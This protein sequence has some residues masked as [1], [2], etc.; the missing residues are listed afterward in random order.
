MTT[1]SAGAL[2]ASLCRF[3][4]C[5]AS[6]CSCSVTSL[7]CCSTGC[8]RRK[9]AYLMMPGCV[10]QSCQHT[11]VH[12]MHIIHVLQRQERQGRCCNAAMHV[13]GNRRVQTV[14]CFV[15]ACSTLRC[16]ILTVAACPPSISEK[17]AAEH[18]VCIMHSMCICFGDQLPSSYKRNTCYLDMLLSQLNCSKYRSTQLLQCLCLAQAE[19]LHMHSVLQGK[20]CS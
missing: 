10:L 19:S 20:L 11:A 6:S 13:R 14:C 12:V 2:A 16:M 7:N 9:L 8:F 15:H 1:H 18:K 17:D 5:S 3:H 4:A